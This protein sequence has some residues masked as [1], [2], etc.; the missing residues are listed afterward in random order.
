MTTWLEVPVPAG[1]LGDVEHAA[2]ALHRLAQASARDVDALEALGPGVHDDWRGQAG[3]AFAAKSQAAGAAVLAVA[4]VEARAAQLLDEYAAELRDAEAA[5]ARAHDDVQHAVERYLHAAPSALGRVADALGGFL[6]GALDALLDLASH[7]LGDVQHAL[8]RVSSWHPPSARPLRLP[9]SALPGAPVGADDVLHALR[10][11]GEW[12]V[13]HLLDAAKGVAHLV[14][15]GVSHAIDAVHAV[16]EALA[17]AVATAHRL[18]HAALERLFAA[19]RRV[20]AA[21][22]H[23]AAELGRSVLHAVTTAV[24][25][26][27]DLLVKAG[28]ALAHLGHLVSEAL[29][30]L[31]GVGDALQR[32]LAG[33][34]EERRMADRL[35][36]DDRAYREF[37]GDPERQRYV[38]LRRQ[39]NELVYGNDDDPRKAPAGWTR[40]TLHGK[41]GFDAVVF[42][43]PS[44]GEVV[45]AF[46]GSEKVLED[47]AQ[48]G[49]N[50]GGL[51]TQ[52]ALQAVALAQ[53]VA[54]EHPGK[55]T[56]TG[57]SLGGSLAAVASLSTGLEAT[58]FNAAGVG[59]GNYAYAV[60]AGRGIGASEQQ[61]TNF[62]TPNDV[63]TVGQDVVG[64]RPASGAQVTIA[65][66]TRNPVAAHGPEHFDWSGLAPSSTR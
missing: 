32:A 52:Q 26:G 11:G 25:A 38:D 24:E 37:Y 20:G 22:Q 53:R 21:L 62:H 7:L 23:A 61:I 12:G 3:S 13:S 39:M 2:R 29:A 35:A 8:S 6:D 49:Q 51:P 45:V 19:A 65:S 9:V 59:D 30:G 34:R 15:S 18:V 10:G 17:E 5:A 56:F 43:N 66:N 63:L 48:N 57:H 41:E 42:T 50:V 14:G 31:R 40:E 46:R 58:T 16:E 33:E 36:A 4:E 60:K 44:T 54:S 28:A 55:V 27:V 64:V 1:D 47:W